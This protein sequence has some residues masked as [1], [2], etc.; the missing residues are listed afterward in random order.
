[1][2]RRL[3]L[4]LGIAAALAVLLLVGPVALAVA[5]M[6]SSPAAQGPDLAA[7]IFIAALTLAAASVAGFAVWG[8]ARLVARLARR[9]G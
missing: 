1:M 7:Q 3:P 5:L 6:R 4:V 2:L 8:L 9:G